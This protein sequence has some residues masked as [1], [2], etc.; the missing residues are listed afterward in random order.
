MCICVCLLYVC[1]WGGGVT[2]ALFSPHPS[3]HQKLFCMISSLKFCSH[4]WT[5]WWLETHRTRQPLLSL[6]RSHHP[7]CN[8]INSLTGSLRPSV[9]VRPSGFRRAGAERCFQTE[10]SA[11]PESLTREEKQLQHWTSAGSESGEEFW[12]SQRVLKSSD[13]VKD[14]RGVAEWGQTVQNW[15]V[16][17]GCFFFFFV[18][19]DSFE[20]EEE[21]WN[22]AAINNTKSSYHLFHCWLVLGYPLF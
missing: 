2:G 1:V 10:R 3:L 19:V 20:E 6:G 17:L 12:L 22:R 8:A 11:A 18:S 15:D 16:F 21:V 13:S 7:Q 14:I 9:R 4:C 5:C